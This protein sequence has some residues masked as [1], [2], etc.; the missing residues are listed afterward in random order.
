MS[1]STVY[2][3]EILSDNF[4]CTDVVLIPIYAVSVPRPFKL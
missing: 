1:N 3:Y 4:V 2:V